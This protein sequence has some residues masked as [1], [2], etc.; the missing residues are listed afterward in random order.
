MI[1]LDD[2]KIS[3][4]EV[5]LIKLTDRE[6]TKQIDE[7]VINLSI[8]RAIAL[9][10]SYLAQAGFI[11]ANFTLSSKEVLKHHASD[12]ARYYLYENRMIEIV[13]ERFNQA[14]KWLELVAKN[15]NMLQTEALPPDE[16]VKISKIAVKAN[17]PEEFK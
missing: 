2:L 10:N 12:I 14:I 7:S 9:V 6:N 4:G 5:E 17:H 11:Q 13:R 8:N 1:T 3:F 16:A 15:P